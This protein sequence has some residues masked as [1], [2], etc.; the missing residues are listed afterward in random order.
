M[1]DI[2]NTVT[3]MIAGYVFMALMMAGYILALWKRVQRK[4]N[5]IKQYQN[6]ETEAGEGRDDLSE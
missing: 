1:N 3:Y 2:P 4:I 5:Q 6:C